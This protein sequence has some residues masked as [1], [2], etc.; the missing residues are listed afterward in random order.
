LYC[1]NFNNTRTAREDGAALA[2]LEFSSST[3]IGVRVVEERQKAFEKLTWTGRKGWANT[4]R[5][6]CRRKSM[7]TTPLKGLR[8]NLIVRKSLRT[9]QKCKWLP[10]RYQKSPVVLFDS[11]E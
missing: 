3:S 2:L 4:A 8:V 10:G 9:G 6:V 1:S 5:A 7:G 11:L